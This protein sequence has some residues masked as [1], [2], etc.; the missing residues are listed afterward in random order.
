LEQDNYSIQ[1]FKKA[2]IEAKDTHL[3]DLIIR[4]PDSC[5]NL[6]QNHKVMKLSLDLIV[7]KPRNVSI[8]YV[9]N[10]L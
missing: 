2:F 9:L 6:V 3:G 5:I 1:L 10:Y 7:S 4:I 8:K